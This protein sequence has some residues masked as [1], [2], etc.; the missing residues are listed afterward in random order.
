MK[1]FQFNTNYFKPIFVVNSEEAENVADPFESIPSHSTTRKRKSDS[2]LFEVNLHNSPLEEKNI[3]NRLSLEAD[4]I[5]ENN[6][7]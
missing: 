3:P 2:V 6:S 5:G 1:L 7:F 4:K